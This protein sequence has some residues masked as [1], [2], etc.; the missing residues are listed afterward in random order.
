M[1]VEVADPLQEGDRIPLTLVFE[2]A[3]DVSVTVDVR[4]QAP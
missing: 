2:E 1:C 4:G 3:G